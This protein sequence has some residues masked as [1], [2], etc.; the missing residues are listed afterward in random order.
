V[1]RCSQPGGNSPVPAVVA[2]VDIIPSSAA[3]EVDA[4]R[5]VEDP[6][7]GDEPRSSGRVLEYNARLSISAV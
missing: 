1:W 2:E 3:L 4:G 7:A 6:G 5:E